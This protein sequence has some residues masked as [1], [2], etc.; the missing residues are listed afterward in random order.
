MLRSGTASSALKIRAVGSRADLKRFVEYPFAKYRDDP[1]WVPPLLIAERQKFDPRKNPFYEH[2]RVELFLAYGAGE[3]VVGRIAAIDDDNHNRTHNDN[4]SF[5]GFFE[6]NDQ[7][8]AQALLS[9]VEDWGRRLGRS[10]VRGPVNPSMNDGAGF[11]I[12][13]FD[14][15]PYVMMPYNPPEYPRYVEAAGYRKAKDL[16]AWLFERD[17]EMG[18]KIGRLAKRVRARYQAV[19]RPVDMKRYDEE[20]ALIKKLYDEAWEENWGFVKYTEAEF[21]HL[22]SELKRIVDPDL[23]R[24]V[25]LKGQVAGMGICIP[26]V[27]QVLKRARGRLLPFGIAAFLRRDKI[28]DQLRLAILGLKPEFRNK[29]LETVLVDELYGPAIEKGYQRCECSWVLE[30]NRAMNRAL[31]VSGAKLYKTYRVYQKEL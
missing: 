4:L 2:A 30:D 21:D 3:E 12:D 22:A 27:N 15:E 28:I 24:F 31:A 29:G 19:T 9:H 16:Y 8:A 10:A 6:A 14:T 5:F 13:A 18:E 20:L 7:M 11:Q 1:H 25:E 23:A 17:Q 26:D